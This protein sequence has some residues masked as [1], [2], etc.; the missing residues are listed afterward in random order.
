M[1]KGL[2]LDTQSS[3]PFSTSQKGLYLTASNDLMVYRGNDAAPQ[4]VSAAI[5]GSLPAG[6][7]TTSLINGSGSTLSMYQPVTINTSGDMIAVDVSSSRSKAISGVLPAAVNNT[8][9][10]T[11]YIAGRLE[12]ITGFNFGDVIYVAKN[13]TL[14]NIEP[15]TG[16][17]GF[18][19]GDYCIKIGVITKNQTTPANKD[20]LINI[21]VIGQLP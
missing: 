6:T 21:S 4:N 17:D 1:A 8:S 20:L 16:S 3:N 9:Q 10:G 2:V 18:V 7:V 5:S 12:N 15:N 13:G 11:V 14:T 19:S